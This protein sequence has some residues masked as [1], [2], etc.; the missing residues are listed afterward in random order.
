M[1]IHVG[2]DAVEEAILTWV[3]HMATQGHGN[4]QVSVAQH[5]VCSLSVCVSMF[6]P[7]AKMMAIVYAEAGYIWV[8]GPPA[9]ENSFTVCADARNH[10]KGHEPRNL[11]EQISYFPT[12][13][14][15]HTVEKEE[16]EG[17]LCPSLPSP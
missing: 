3:A 9:N 17:L 14:G 8:L 2:Q 5:Q 13:S 7:N 6:P 11:K 15:R 1:L 10:M 4:V 16:H 12:L